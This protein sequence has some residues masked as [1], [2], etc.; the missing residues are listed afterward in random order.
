M[1]DP[2]KRAAAER[3]RILVVTVPG[4]SKAPVEVKMEVRKAPQ[5]DPTRKTVAFYT[6]LVSVFASKSRPF[7]YT[8]AP[9]APPNGAPIG[10]PASEAMEAVG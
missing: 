4:E 8:V 1:T 6:R 2:P 7:G 3:P 5:A 9:L 10:A